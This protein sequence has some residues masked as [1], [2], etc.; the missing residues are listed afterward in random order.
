MMDEMSA[1]PVDSLADFLLD[2]DIPSDFVAV[3]VGEYIAS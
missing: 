1:R 3:F 2:N